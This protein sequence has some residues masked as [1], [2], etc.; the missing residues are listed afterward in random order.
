MACAHTP[1]QLSQVQSERRRRAI[2]GLWD[3]PGPIPEDVMQRLLA[4]K[5]LD[6]VTCNEAASLRR[7]AVELREQ[8]QEELAAGLEGVLARYEDADEQSLGEGV[9]EIRFRDCGLTIADRALCEAAANAVNAAGWPARYGEQSLRSIA[10][11]LWELR[12][13]QRPLSPLGRWPDS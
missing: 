11:R 8:G 10:S 7:S 13:I 6:G 4:I 3:E 5:P 12:G 1:A 9:A 2:E